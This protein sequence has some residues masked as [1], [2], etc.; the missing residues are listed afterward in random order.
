[1]V[2]A[3]F[4]CVSFFSPFSNKKQL[5]SGYTCL[6]KNA[7]LGETNDPLSSKGPSLKQKLSEAVVP[8]MVLVLPT[9]LQQ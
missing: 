6:S 3:V 9:A 5:N 7:R 2:V 4:L 1:M 8:G